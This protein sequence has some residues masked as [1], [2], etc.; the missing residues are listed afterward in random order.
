MPHS[1]ILP[2]PMYCSGYRANVASMTTF[3]RRVIMLIPADRAARSHEY[4][5][6]EEL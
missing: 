4:R 3:L 5:F 2:P 6:P 1:Y